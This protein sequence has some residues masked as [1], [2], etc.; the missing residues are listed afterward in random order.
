MRK[1]LIILIAIITCI[2][3]VGAERN[4]PKQETIDFE[5]AGFVKMSATAYCVGHHTADGSAVFE[6]G[7]ASSLDHIGDVAIVYTLD[8]EFLGY[9]ICNDTGK[10]G[11]G[12]RAGNVLDI[13][14]S[15]LESCQ[16]LMTF[17]GKEQ[18]VWVKWIEGNG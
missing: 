2:V 1:G 11:G 10:E 5:Q 16:E 12:V 9:L 3:F 15:D 8:N 17:L 4:E 18:K 7:C 6:G 14:R 13:Y